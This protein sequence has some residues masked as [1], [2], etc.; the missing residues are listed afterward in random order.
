MEILEAKDGECHKNG[1]KRYCHG[2]GSSQMLRLWQLQSKSTRIK[3]RVVYL[4]GTLLVC[5]RQYSTRTTHQKGVEEVVVSEGKRRQKTS[6]K[7]QSSNKSSD[8]W[9]STT[10]NIAFDDLRV[11]VKH[12]YDNHPTTHFGHEGLS[13]NEIR[14]IPGQ[15]CTNEK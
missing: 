15:V 7:G 12:E 13:F 1:Y 5:T 9:K 3:S 4:L 8:K 6:G 10:A 14:E 11:N 2:N